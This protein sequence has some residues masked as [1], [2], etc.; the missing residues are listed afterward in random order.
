MR[1]IFVATDDYWILPR[2]V[3]EFGKDRIISQE[4]VRSKDQQAVHTNLNHSNRY[5]LGLEVLTDCYALSSCDEA[6]LS[7]SN[8]SYSALLLNP[9]LKYTLLETSS[10]RRKRYLTGFLYTMDRWGIR[11]M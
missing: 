2:L 8:V 9:E 6:I 1:K 11:K 7:H 5:K 4:A 3:E 10:Y